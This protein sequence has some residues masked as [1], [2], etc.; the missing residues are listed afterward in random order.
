MASYVLSAFHLYAATRRQ[1]RRS[2]H[3]HVIGTGRPTSICL[4]HNSR[5]VLRQ[6]LDAILY[7]QVSEGVGPRRSRCVHG[8]K[9]KR[10][11]IVVIEAG[12]NSIPRRVNHRKLT[13]F[14]VMSLIFGMVGQ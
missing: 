14:Q 1:S 12:Q 11:R 10:E 9:G 8:Q 2:T 7:H 6:S 4:I 13:T 5:T 3:P